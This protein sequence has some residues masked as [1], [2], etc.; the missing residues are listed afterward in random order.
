[1]KSWI[2]LLAVAAGLLSPSLAAAA[3]V[4]LVSS[5]LVERRS[6]AADGTETVSLVPA[7]RVVPGD[8]LRFV[9]RYKNASDKAAADFVI[10]NPIPASV[11]FIAADG[12]IAP[13]VSVDGG[14]TFGTLSSRVVKQPDGTERPAR[15]D[16][17][18]HVKW[19][20]AEKLAGGS[21]GEV[22]FRAELR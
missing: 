16:E 13:I 1:M 22:A 4:E 3:P 5:V 17:V 21:A 9:I 7:E 15:A 19:Q 20:F 12:N 11:A 2:V 18:T 14:A 8:K 6:V 10:T